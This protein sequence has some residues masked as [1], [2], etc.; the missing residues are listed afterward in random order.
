M[1]LADFSDLLPTF[2]N[3][4]GA[5]VP[6]ELVIDGRSFANV[7]LGRAPK[8]PR[9]VI[10]NQ[11]GKVRV[12]RNLR[13]KLYSDGRLYDVSRDFDETRDLSGSSDEAVAAARRQLRAFLN[14]LPPN[15]VPPFELRSQAPQQAEESVAWLRGNRSG[16]RGFVRLS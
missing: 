13:Y 2:C 5:E 11:F 3:L 8:G 16:W 12:V 10:F 14:S 15:A 9:D 1:P 6:Q 7:V 4:A